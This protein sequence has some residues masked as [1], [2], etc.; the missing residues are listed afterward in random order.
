[1]AGEIFQVLDYERVWRNGIISE[2]EK[3]M[4]ELVMCT[5]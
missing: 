5:K 1:M 2:T 4:A 3:K